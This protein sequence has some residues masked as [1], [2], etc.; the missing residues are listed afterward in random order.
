[1]KKDPRFQGILAQPLRPDEDPRCK[2]P[3]LRKALGAQT[4]EDGFLALAKEHIPGFKEPRQGRPRFINASLSHGKFRADLPPW[5]LAVLEER[6]FDGMSQLAEWAVFGGK[7]SKDI[8]NAFYLA[9]TWFLVGHLND[10]PTLSQFAKAAVEAF[11]NRRRRA[12]DY[13][14]I[15]ANMKRR[16]SNWDLYVGQLRAHSLVLVDE[17]IKRN[18][19]ERNHFFESVLT[20]LEGRALYFQFVDA[21]ADDIDC[22]GH[23]AEGSPSSY[24]K[25]LNLGARAFFPNATGVHEIDLP[26]ILR[27][28]GYCA[29]D[30][31][32]GY[33]S[34]DEDWSFVGSEDYEQ[35][36]SEYRQAFYTQITQVCKDIKARQASEAILGRPNNGPTQLRYAGFAAPLRQ[37]ALN[38]RTLQVC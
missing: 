17:Y 2:L 4:D 13:D 34:K 23:L 27:F 30:Y 10:R 29:G 11:H 19:L 1:M 5:M 3:E 28:Y 18:H 6:L 26:L 25:S 12:A 20:M 31:R 32:H 35:Y 33:V 14:K 15:M 24:K 9:E 37:G 22:D 38:A 7:R 36:I 8:D 21:I 16:Y